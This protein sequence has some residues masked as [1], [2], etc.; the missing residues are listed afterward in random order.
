MITL[1]PEAEH[2][3]RLL[4]ARSRVTPEQALKEAL[5]TQARIVGVSIADGTKP[6]KDI[7]LDRVHRITQRVSSRPILDHRTPEAIL[8]QG[9]GHHE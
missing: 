9:W 6:A 2:L 5:E 8:N 4:A 1:S 7:D 3:A